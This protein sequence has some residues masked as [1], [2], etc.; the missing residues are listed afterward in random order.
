MLVFPHVDEVND[1]QPAQVAQPQ[2]S[3]NLFCRLHVRLEGGVFNAPFP[4]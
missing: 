2:L 3:C 4:A 1:N